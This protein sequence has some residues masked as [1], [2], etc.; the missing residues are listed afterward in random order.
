LPFPSS[1]AKSDNIHLFNSAK[2]TAQLPPRLAFPLAA[3]K[4]L[5][6]R[7]LYSL[8]DLGWESGK[9]RVR[10]QGRPLTGS[11]PDSIVIFQSPITIHQSQS[12]W[13]F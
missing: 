2:K 1:P 8:R 6:A 13:G 7:D 10:L 5:L 3:K 4:V 12:E 11:A 9:I